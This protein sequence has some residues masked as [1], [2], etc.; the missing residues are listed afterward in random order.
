MAVQSVASSECLPGIKRSVEN[1]LGLH[2]YNA[3]NHA[4]E[5]VI[6]LHGYVRAL[7]DTRED[8]PL[9][10]AYL[11]KDRIKYMARAVIDIETWAIAVIEATPEQISESGV[12]PCH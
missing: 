12:Q 8:D 5:N 4:R 3:E 11:I 9:L 2:Y 1:A 7:I 6:R 10:Y